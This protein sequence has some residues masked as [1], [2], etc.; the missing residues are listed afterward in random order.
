MKFGVKVC[1]IALVDEGGPRQLPMT[2]WR[3]DEGEPCEVQT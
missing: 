3:V 1:P 2:Q